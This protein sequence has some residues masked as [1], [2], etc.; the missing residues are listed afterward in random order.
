MPK[1]K[2]E[3][4]SVSAHEDGERCPHCAPKIERPRERLDVPPSVRTVRAMRNRRQVI[5]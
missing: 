1:L 4:E 5:E 2:D 3:Q